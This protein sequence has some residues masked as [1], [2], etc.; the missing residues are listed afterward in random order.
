MAE[1]RNPYRWTVRIVAVLTLALLLGAPTLSG[2]TSSVA[3]EGN[4][5]LQDVQTQQ[6]VLDGGEGVAPLEVDA[7]LEA[8]LGKVIVIP[9][10]AFVHDG[11]AGGDYF[12]SI[13]RGYVVGM[14]SGALM[15]APLILPEGA[16]KINGVRVY[17]HDANSG[18]SASFCLR[19][20]TLSTGKNDLLGCVYT[21][22]S[23]GVEVY[24]IIPTRKYVS[25]DRAYQLT[26]EMREDVRVYGI[27]VGYR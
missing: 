9:P 4:P 19:R 18:T 16:T 24:K 2:A 12:M 27:K 22:D 6:A 7:G 23:T 5:N 26:V 11:S 1:N 8:T 20:I 14:G 17:A 25:N 10:A 3:Q 15:L 13:A 21:S